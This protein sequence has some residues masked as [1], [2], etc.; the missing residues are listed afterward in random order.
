MHDDSRNADGIG[1][2]VRRARHARGLTLQETADRAGRSKAWLS[3]IENGKASLDRRA[4]IA[5]LAIALE[6]SADTLLGEPAPEVQPGRRPWNL[7]PLRAAL[8]DASPGDPPDIPA[9][10]VPVLAGLCRQADQALRWSRYDELLPLLPALIGELEVHAG[11]GTGPDRDE[12]LRLMIPATATAVI[13]LRWAGQPDLA[14]WAAERGRQAAAMTGD[15]VLAGAAAFS[16]AHARNSANRPRALLATP[17]A[18]DA[19]ES[20][21]GR[22]PF[23]RQVHGMLRLSAALAC[24]VQGDYAGAA[25]HGA[26]AARVAAGTE[27][28]PDAF[29]LFG[30]S[31]VGVWRACLAVEAGNAEDALKFAAGVRPR[32]LASGNRRAALKIERARALSMLGKRGADGEAITELRLA[33]RMSPAQVHGS[34]LLRELVRDLLD[35]A[36]GRDLRGLAWRMGVI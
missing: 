6:V 17:R 27:D 21:A 33:E 25:G 34:P 35:R 3:N 28:D 30:P 12:A 26:E 36:A 11:T 16:A 13:A 5:A 14:T 2:S 32:A 31:N 1:L 10:P 23:A 9:R 18:A 7:T 4:D 20:L 22:D 24:A 15:P 8:L 29:E 19:L